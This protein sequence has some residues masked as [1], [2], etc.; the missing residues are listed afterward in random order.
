MK[1]ALVDRVGM[2]PPVAAALDRLTRP[3]EVCE[4][5]WAVRSAVL[6]DRRVDDDE[7]QK[8]VEEELQFLEA[9]ERVKAWADLQGLAALRRLREAVGEQVR[10]TDDLAGRVG[11]GMR[12]SALR[13]ESD[14]ATVDEVVLATGLPQWQVDAG[15]TWPWMPTVEVGCCPRRWRRDACRSIGRSGSITTLA[16]SGRRRSTRSASGCSRRTATAAFAPTAPSGASCV[17]R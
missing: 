1:A 15:S 9:V 17:V 2:A 13:W 12:P 3:H 4:A 10:M 11:R 8:W 7:S 16:G 6:H 5:G 14:T